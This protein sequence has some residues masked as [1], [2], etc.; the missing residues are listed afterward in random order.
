MILIS[1]FLAVS[2]VAISAYDR[3]LRLSFLNV[4]RRVGQPLKVAG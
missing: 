4:R 1:G 3:F 2:V